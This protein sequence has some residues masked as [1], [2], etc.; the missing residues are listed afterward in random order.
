LRGLAKLRNFTVDNFKAIRSVI[1]PFK[2][3]D[4]IFYKV[5]QHEGE[6]NKSIEF[7]TTLLL[8]DKFTVSEIANFARV[9]EVFVKKVRH[10]SK[11]KN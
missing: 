11:Q 8:A 6:I 7:V 2:K 10:E 4:D 5:G 1:I 3:E 9:D